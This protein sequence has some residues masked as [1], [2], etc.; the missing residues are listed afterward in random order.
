M[1]FLKDFFIFNQVLDAAFIV[2]WR[3]DHFL[4]SDHL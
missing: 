2:D 3:I 1:Y 4:Q